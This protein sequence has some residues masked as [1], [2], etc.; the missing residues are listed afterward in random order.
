MTTSIMDLILT[1]SKKDS[2][3]YGTKNNDTQIS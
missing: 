1:I 2:E 3:Y